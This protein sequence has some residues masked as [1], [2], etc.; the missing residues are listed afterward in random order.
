MSATDLNIPLSCW[1]K[2]V[3]VILMG[4][5]NPEVTSCFIFCGKTKKMHSRNVVAVNLAIAIVATTAAHFSCRL[6]NISLELSCK[7]EVARTNQLYTYVCMYEVFNASTFT[8]A[9]LF[10]K[11]LSISIHNSK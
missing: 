1:R 4:V 5:R 10:T 9:A 11:I 3:K 6:L 2:L 8:S 7:H